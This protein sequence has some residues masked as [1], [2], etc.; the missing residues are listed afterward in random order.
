[1]QENYSFLL[2]LLLFA[3]RN[4]QNI[5]GIQTVYLSRCHTH[6]LR[7]GDALFQAIF[8]SFFFCPITLFYLIPYDSVFSEL[9]A[10]FLI[11][12]VKISFRQDLFFLSDRLRPACRRSVY[13]DIPKRPI[14]TT[15]LLDKRIRPKYKTLFIND[16]LFEQVIP[17]GSLVGR[18]DLV[19]IILKCIVSIKEI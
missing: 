13:S 18:N 5:N 14:K 1:M 12:L 10:A 2:P 6:F 8:I 3:V 11:L 19:S 9:I 4:F 7:P 16:T 17:S 15:G